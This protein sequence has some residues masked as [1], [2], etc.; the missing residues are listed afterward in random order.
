MT[1]F[2]KHLGGKVTGNRRDLVSETI[3]IKTHS[4]KAE[5]KKCNEKKGV[6]GRKKGSQQS[7]GE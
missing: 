5:G 1:C 2:H 3:T 6:Y 4:K 7:S